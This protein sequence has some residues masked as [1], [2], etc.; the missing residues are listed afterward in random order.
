[1]K[2]KFH[3]FAFL[4]S[5]FFA[6]VMAQ[7]VIRGPYLQ[8]NTPNSIIIRWRTDA[9]TDSKVWYGNSHS[10]L[11]SISF[12]G[13][14]RTEHEVKITG[15]TPNTT[16]FYAIGN[17]G[18]QLAGADPGHFFKTSPP[19]GT[20]QPVSMWV[21]GDAGKISVEQRAVRDGF[22]T[23][24]GGPSA[25]LILL[26]GDNAY[27]DGTDEEFQGAWFENMYESS[28]INSP[29]WPSI[30]N[31]DVISANSA[32]ETGPYYDIFNMPRNGEAGGVPSGTEAWYSFDYANIHFIVLNTEDVDHTASSPM[33]AWLE[34]DIAATNQEWIV[35]YF[36]KQPYYTV[37]EFR[38]NFVPVLEAG[39]VDLVMYGHRHIYRRSFLMNGHYGG[40]GSFDFNTMAVDQGDGRTDGDGAY[41]KPPGKTPNSGTVYLVSGSAGSASLINTNYPFVVHEYGRP[42]YGSTH[43]SVNGGQM[44]VRFV[45]TQGQVL[46]YFTI[47]K[48]IGIRPNVNI[49]SPADGSEYA[50]VQPIT[51]TADASDPD[52]QVTQVEFLANGVS[53]GV[54][55]SA[56]FSL[57]WAPPT[58]GIYSLQAAATDNDNN[59]TYSAPVVI[60]VGI[61]E[62]CSSIGFPTDD[63]EQTIEDGTMN[64]TSSDLEL[65]QDAAEQIV[66]LRF[67]GFFIPKN[68]Q[69]VSAEIKFV[70]DKTNG[71]DPCD[72]NIYGIASPDPGTFSITP[73]DLKD[74]PRTSASVAWTPNDWSSIGGA[75]STS[76]IKRII[77]EL[78]NQDG[79][80]AGNAFGFLI[81][82]TGKRTA[83]SWNGNQA[84]APQL[85]IVYTINDSGFE[86]AAIGADIGTPCDDGDPCTIDDVIQLDCTCAGIPA[87]DSDNDGTCDLQD[88]CN[89]GFEPGTPCDDGDINTYDDVIDENCN[90]TGTSIPDAGT[91]SIMV[92]D[93]SDDAE[94]EISD[95]SVSLTS[96]D[97]EL[98]YEFQLLPI[99][100]LVGI[101]FTNII[102]PQ[103]ARITGAYIQFTVDEVSTGA[104]ELLIEGEASDNAQIFSNS[105]SNLS[106]RDRTNASATWNPVDWDE[107]DLDGPDQRTVNI[108]HIVQEI[109]DRPGWQPL[110]SMA[111]FISGT[112]TRTA[113][114]YDG[115][116]AGP[117]LY[118][119]YDN[120]LDCTGA[121]APCDD[122]DS[123]TIG[124]VFDADCNCAGTFQDSDDDGICDEYDACP[125]FDDGADDDGDGVAD[126]CDACVGDDAAGDSDEDGVCDDIDN[127]PLGY[128]PSQ[129]DADGD[130]VGDGCDSPKVSVVVY[131]QGAYD[132][133]AG[134]M[135]DDLRAN[136]LLPLN[137]PYTGLGYAHI[138]GGGESTQQA[139]LDIEGEDAIVDWVFLELRDKA[140]PSIVRATGSALLQADGDVVDVDGV[141]PVE[142]ASLP[143]GEYYVAVKHR[144]HIGVMSA[145]PITLSA[146]V[147]VMDF[148]TDIDDIFG[149]G[150]SVGVLNDGKL[151][152]FSGDFNHN[153]QAQNT[154]YNAMV[155]TLGL[156]GYQAGDFDLNGQVQNTDLQLYLV[157]NL[158]RGG[159]FQ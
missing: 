21:L 87:L 129:S 146:V 139:I 155:Q 80:T 97:L 109:V 125:G 56:P 111:F 33:L 158:G 68:A 124:D 89:G 150:N 127:C 132:G 25:D 8:L 141:S 14:S 156:A 50:D 122:G 149:G 16:Y 138:G 77:Q 42:N 2:L 48:G 151:G 130:G 123:C 100:Q 143:A 44:D 86:C 71:I 99:A 154:D 35:A 148:T 147:A 43:V 115:S 23:Y 15:L 116:G 5:F 59:T 3:L 92:D 101:R 128:N 65:G 67:Q 131:L 19:H 142:F 52:G 36:H 98:G 105:L 75:R 29:V 78:V 39:G 95:G 153:M 85:C 110:N 107:T 1:M 81:E 137:E 96:S 82:G 45:D 54:D 47:S 83:T 74:R 31:H 55:Q 13:G 38:R 140:D 10:N 34:Q 12:L 88:V 20:S 64:L 62:V 26:L 91:I 17:S 117:V 104:S 6:D 135:R 7:S 60:Q 22:Y 76:N 41:E 145:T 57:Q 90:C 102:L 134:R 70:V 136:N 32:M 24:N 152:L 49:T 113:A 51:I 28:L 61:F 72:L 53:I 37:G 79:Y 84:H 133:G 46:D 93:E 106:T 144:N 118:I 69:I 4:L 126:G 27:E 18:G 94:E 73:Y 103:G 119:E 121:G 120:T 159:A 66:G 30:G 114:S 11:T 108:A 157:P 112:G 40:E 63:A 58:D 9:A